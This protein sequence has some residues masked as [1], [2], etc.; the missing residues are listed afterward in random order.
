MPLYKVDSNNK[1]VR[2]FTRI[3]WQT[4]QSNLNAFKTAINAVEKNEVTGEGNEV[5][6]QMWNELNIIYSWDCEN[7]CDSRK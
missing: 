3:I 6:N 5:N 2:Y 7:D 1:N 4:L